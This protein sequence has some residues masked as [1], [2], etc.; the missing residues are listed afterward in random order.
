MGM[1]V[2]GCPVCGLP[3]YWFSGNLDQR[4][5]ICKTESGTPRGEAGDR[6]GPPVSPPSTSEAGA[7]SGRNT[8][9]KP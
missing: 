1:Y 2:I 7:G 8:G 9:A 6:A 5:A 3:H 4:C